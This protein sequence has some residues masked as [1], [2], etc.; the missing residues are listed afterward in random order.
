MNPPDTA[1]PVTGLGIDGR[2]LRPGEVFVA[3][4][5]ERFDGHDFLDQA[6]AARAALAI[7]ER[8]PSPEA[9]HPALPLLL[10]PS[11]LAAR[12]TLA[13]HYREVLGAGGCRNL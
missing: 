7:V 11:T 12:Q 8:T 9:Q 1:T 10:V 13:W 6:R 2:T 3:I 5:G 4:P